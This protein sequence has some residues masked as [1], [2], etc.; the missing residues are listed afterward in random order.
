MRPVDRVGRLPERLDRRPV[1]DPVGRGQR[2]PAAWPQSAQQ[3]GG[4]HVGAHETNTAEHFGQIEVGRP[5]D[6]H[7]VDVDQLVVEDVL[8][9]QHLARAA[10]DVAQVEPGRAQ[11]HLGVRDAIDGR[12]GD[13]GQAAAPPG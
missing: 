11:Q 3:R 2:A 4:G 10:D 9:Q 8:G 12:G 13:E 1:D 5:D 7:A 6:L